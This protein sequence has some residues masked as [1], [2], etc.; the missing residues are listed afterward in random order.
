VWLLLLLP[1]LCTCNQTDSP[2]QELNWG[3]EETVSDE[4]TLIALDSTQ[5]DVPSPE[6]ADQDQ[7]DLDD[8]E[9]E[10]E[11][12]FGEEFEEEDDDDTDS[13]DSADWDIEI[14]EPCHSDAD[15]PGDDNPCCSCTAQCID[16]V[17]VQSCLDSECCRFKLCGPEC[18]ILRD[19]CRLDQH[20]PELLPF[21]TDGLCGECAAHRHCDD[22]ARP[23]CE[24]GMCSPI[25]CSLMS[26]PSFAP[27]CI[28]GFC[29]LDTCGPGDPCLSARATCEEGICRLDDYDVFGLSCHFQVSSQ[30]WVSL[31]EDWSALAPVSSSD[32]NALLLPVWY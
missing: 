19:P 32:G 16:G 29:H 18:E 14:R 23:S 13:N 8:F 27:L 4:E 1:L 3:D 22:S 17:C 10:F 20:C 28:G 21:C 5:I 12:E 30:G 6:V 15:C 9:E 31:G 2:L 25:D 7:Q 26:C 11:E 24:Q